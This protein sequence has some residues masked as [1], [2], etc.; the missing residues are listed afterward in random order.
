MPG[1]GQDLPE[2]EAGCSTQPF[3]WFSNSGHESSSWRTWQR[4]LLEDWTLFSGRWPRSGMMRNGI[5]YRLPPLVRRISGTECSSSDIF[6]T[7]YGLSA[8][9]GQGDGEFGKAIRRSVKLPAPDANC[10]KAGNRGGG[11]GGGLQLSNTTAMRFPTPRAEDSQCAGG[12]RGK[13]DT[14]Y[15]AI[16]KPAD[17]ATDT[18]GQLNPTWVEWLMGFPLGW[19]DCDAS[20]TPSCHKSQSGSEGE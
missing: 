10:L 2:N 20:E 18:P 17:K 19:T 16:C 13:D 9:Q 1:E 12:H 4:C 15:G 14:L 8:N 7:P 6:P 11:T 5:A 3:A